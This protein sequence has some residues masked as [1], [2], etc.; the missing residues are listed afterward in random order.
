M[1]KKMIKPKGMAERL[2]ITVL[3]LQR[4][5]S[6][7][8]IEHQPMVLDNVDTSPDKE[9]VDDLISIIH[10]FSCHLYGLHR[11]K[12]KISTDETLGGEIDGDQ[13]TKG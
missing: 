11:Y 13:D 10:V 7:K 12:H 5:D 2:G 3:T 9:L 6:W 8:P 4:W 1:P